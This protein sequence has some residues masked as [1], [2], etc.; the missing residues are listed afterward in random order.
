MIMLPF[1]VS[2]LLQSFY[3]KLDHKYVCQRGK[4]NITSIDCGTSYRFMHPLWISVFIH[5]DKRGYCVGLNNRKP[6][7]GFLE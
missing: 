7:A 2:V 6:M 5:T 1:V 4:K 3:L